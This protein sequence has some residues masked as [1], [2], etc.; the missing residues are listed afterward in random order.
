MEPAIADT[1]LTDMQE[2][3]RSNGLKTY[4]SKGTPD[5]GWTIHHIEATGRMLLVI[6]QNVLLSGEEG[7]FDA[8]EPMSDPGQFALNVIP[9]RW[10]PFSRGRALKLSDT[11]IAGLK[12][13]G[14]QVLPQPAVPCSITF[15]RGAPR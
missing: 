3:L 6:V 12:S 15:L 13:R 5:T 9:S 7:C 10:V 4:Y 8:R 11:L 1:F 14:Y 2:I